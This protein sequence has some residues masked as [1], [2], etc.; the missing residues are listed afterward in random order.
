MP[1]DSLPVLGLDDVGN[2]VELSLDDLLGGSVLSLL[3]GLTDASNDAESGADGSL[4]LV[5]DELVAV[6]EEGSSLRVSEDD[7]VDVGVLE[8]VGGDLSGE[9]TRSLGEGVLGGDLGRGVEELLDRK[10]VERR[11]SDDDLCGVSEPQKSSLG[12]GT[13]DPTYQSCR[14]GWRC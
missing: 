1:I 4:D 11:R 6:S 9:G 3:E 12:V 10:E 7:P 5:S 13:I 14:R 2:S 8:L